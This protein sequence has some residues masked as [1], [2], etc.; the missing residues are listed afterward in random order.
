M[1]KTQFCYGMLVGSLLIAS[2]VRAGEYPASDFQ[3]KVLFQDESVTASS[4]T[5]ASSSAAPCVNQEAA[6][7]KEE[8]AEFDPQYPASSFQPKVIFSDAN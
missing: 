1:K 4:S 8:V 2:S 5:S 7:K 6:S 3:P